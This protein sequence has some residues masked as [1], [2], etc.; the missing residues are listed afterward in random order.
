MSIIKSTLLILALS[1]FVASCNKDEGPGGTASIE[2]RL[3]QIVHDDDH[4][5]PTSDTILAVKHD[6]YLVYGNDTYF[7]DDTETDEDGSFRFQYLTPGSYTIYAYSELASGEKIAVKRHITLHRGE[8]IQVE[9]LFVENGKAFGTSMIKGWVKATYFDKNGNTIRSTWGYDQRVYIQRLGEEYHFND[10]RVG[11]EGVYYFQ[12]LLP[13]SYVI[14]AFSQYQD[15]SLFPVF[16]TITISEPGL[17]YEA[18]TLNIRI[19]A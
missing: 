18:D 12:K 13:G 1:L 14:Y 2:G 3:F 4:Y 16:D 11:L 19:K 10:T 15:E 9:D 7:G 5:P 8:H 17:I 6:V